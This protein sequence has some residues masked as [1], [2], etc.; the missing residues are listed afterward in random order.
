MKI[1]SLIL[2]LLAGTLLG[3]C[4]ETDYTGNSSES[5]ESPVFDIAMQG[6][7]PAWFERA[8]EG[9]DFGIHRVGK[10]GELVADSAELFRRSFEQMDSN[11]IRYGLLSHGAFKEAFL[12]DRPDM[13]LLSYEPDLSLEDHTAAALEFEESILKGTYAA[14]G[15]LGLIYEGIPLNTRDL[16]PYYEVAQ[17]H[18]IPVLIHTGFSGPNPQQL[19]SP[20]FRIGTANPLLL[21]DVFIDFPDLKVVMMHMGWPFFDEALYM[22]GTYPNVYMETSV[23]IWLLGDQLFN[24]LLSEAVAT[25]GSDKI[26]F[27]TLQMAWP[28]VIG[29]SVRTIR[30]AGYLSPEDK[31]AILW[32][33]AAGLFGIEE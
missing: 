19:L 2:L 28:E 31:H 9:V 3:G 17:K 11:S 13:F 18:G 7:D 4:S 10:Y 30:E 1:L 12:K 22:L 6:V 27:G 5:D 21:E 20:A 26:L 32:Q 15:E 25:A 24:R 14:L 8:M 29:R 23:A 33:N 16:Y